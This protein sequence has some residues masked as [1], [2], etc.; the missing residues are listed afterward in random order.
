[1]MIDVATAF[2]PAAERDEAAAVAALLH[3]G[4]PVSVAADAPLEEA[5][6]TFHRNA[7][8]RLLPVLDDD[9]PVGALFETQLRELLFN[10]FGHA[11]LKNPRYGQSLDRYIR[12]CPVAEARIGLAALL[13]FYAASGGGEGLIVTENGRFLTMLPNRVLIGLAV[14]RE[15]ERLDRVRLA[16]SLFEAEASVLARGLGETAVSLREQASGMVV[17][18]HA[19]R[20]R[21]DAMTH[22]AT[23]MLAGIGGVAARGRDLV[24][25]MDTIQHQTAHARAS[26]HSPPRQTRSAISRR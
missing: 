4:T 25:A 24:S 16:S 26:V 9:R 6:E 10:P 14:Q 3:A 1:M 7:A 18:G 23:E 22:A 20:D 13:D 8:L 2:A 19:T 21:S 5:I 12:S 15:A 17:R 11:L